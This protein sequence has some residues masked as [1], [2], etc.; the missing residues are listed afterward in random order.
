MLGFLLQWPTLPTLIM[1]PILVVMYV[2]LARREEREVRGEFGHI[3]TRYA[4]RTPAFFPRWRRLTQR[5]A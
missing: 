2:R 4:T 1:F 3:Y 5:E